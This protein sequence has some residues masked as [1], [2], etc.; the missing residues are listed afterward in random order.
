[1]VCPNSN[2]NVID[3]FHKIGL[4]DKDLSPE[5][6]ASQRRRL[7]YTVC[8]TFRLFLAGLLFQLRNKK[9]VQ[10]LVAILS[11]LAILNYIFF[12]RKGDEWWNI[13]FSLAI[14]VALFITSILILLGVKIT[15]Y[16]LPFIFFFSIFSGI[17]KSMTR[18]S[19]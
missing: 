18:P 8:I 16:A 12:K 11:G 4:L 17:F 2:K 10:I 1:M 15:T 3:A 7:Y 6:E 13:Y 19:C 5:D 14:Y 9:S